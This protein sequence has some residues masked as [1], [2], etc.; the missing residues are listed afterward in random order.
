MAIS[1]KSW[2]GVAKETTPGTAAATPTSVGWIPAKSLL[3]PK[4]KYEYL[5]EERGTR[6][7]NYGRVATTQMS[8]LTAKGPWYNDSWG[9]FLLAFMGADTPTQPNAGT[10]PTV[11]SHAMAL[12]DIPPALTSFKSY[13]AVTYKAAYTVVEKLQFKFTAE[14]KLLD[15]DATFKGQFATKVSSPPTPAFATTLPFAGYSPTITLSSGATSDIEEMT[16]TLEQKI[17]LFYPANGVQQF[18]A[19]YFGERKVSFDFLARFD[20]DTLYNKFFSNS[21]S[22]DSLSIVFQGQNIAS[23]YNQSMTLNF[24][25]VG[26]DEADHELGKDNV[27]MKVKGYARPGATANSLMTAILQNTVSAYT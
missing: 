2:L 22:D 27:M 17:R 8:T 21:G 11:W 5:D 16:I 26:Y 7:A 6:D 9:Y 14:G 13:D 15:A 18:A 12:A 19:A 10:A 23:T 20:N 25:I 3:I 4:T 1:K 24:P